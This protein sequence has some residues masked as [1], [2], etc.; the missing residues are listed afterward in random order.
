MKAPPSSPSLRFRCAGR[1]GYWR[2]VAA[3]QRARA[4]FTLDDL[5]SLQHVTVQ[6]AIAI[7]NA[8]LFAEEK[9]RNQQLASLYQAATRITSSLDLS[10]VLHMAAKSLVEAA[11]VPGCAIY[12]FR[13]S[14]ARPTRLAAFTANVA[15]RLEFADRADGLAAL[16]PAAVCPGTVGSGWSCSETIPGRS[17]P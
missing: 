8:R 1:G 13:G 11:P 4:G 7:H 10:V 15:N 2:S 12:E 14:E 17:R 6:A 5:D 16:D 9:A 3:P